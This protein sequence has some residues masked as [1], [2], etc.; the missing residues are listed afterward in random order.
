MEMESINGPTEEN[1]LVSGNK[2]KCMEPAFLLGKMEENTKVIT[3]MIK[4]MVM[5]FLLGQ[6]G[7]NMMVPG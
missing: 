3:M 6:T 5:V 4:N 7:G 1:S 2:T